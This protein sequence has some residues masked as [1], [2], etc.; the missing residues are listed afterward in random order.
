MLIFFIEVCLSME[1]SVMFY[2]I[3]QFLLDKKKSF[4]QQNCFQERTKDFRQKGE[5]EFNFG[6]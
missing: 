1:K 5:E 3:S 6:S 2:C 4:L